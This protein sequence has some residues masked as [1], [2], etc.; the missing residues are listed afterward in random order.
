[1]V[2]ALGSPWINRGRAKRTTEC[3]KE[4]KPTLC[5]RVCVWKCSPICLWAYVSLTC[6]SLSVCVCVRITVVMGGGEA[7]ALSPGTDWLVLSPRGALA[8]FVLHGIKTSLLGNT[9]GTVT[10]T[11]QHH[12]VIFSLS[13]PHVYLLKLMHT[14]I[15][16][17]WTISS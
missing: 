7:F 2:S 1:M 16:D 15:T 11:K 14:R 8:V 12:D 17:T 6:M 9:R 4:K 5:M 10:Y 13:R 3:M